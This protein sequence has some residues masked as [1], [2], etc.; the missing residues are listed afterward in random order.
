MLLELVF[1]SIRE[2]D[3]RIS[4]AELTTNSGPILE[5]VGPGSL[6]IGYMLVGI[7]CY[8]VM[9]A[10]VSPSAIDRVRNLI[11]LSHKHRAKWE[12]GFHSRLVSRALRIASLTLH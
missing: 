1:S 3:Y 9:A 12:L 4:N 6:L 2:S 11:G 5:Q 7:L 8:T 10:L